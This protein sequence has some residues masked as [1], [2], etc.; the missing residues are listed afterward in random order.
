MAGSI[1]RS[2]AAPQDFTLALALADALPVLFF[3]ASMI[4]VARNV[5][6]VLFG[7]GAAVITLAGCGKVLWKI[8]LGVWKKNVVWLNRYFIPCQITGLLL[9]LAALAL[10]IPAM[11]GAQL[12]GQLLHF[13]SLLFFL[14]WLAG[15]AVMGWYRKNRFDNSL[16]AN[17]TAQLINTVTQGAL[18]LGIL[19]L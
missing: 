13:P 1:K 3:G 6:S 7:F 17:W 16:K 15:M 19:F 14:V 5:G 9:V 2:A 18:L 11:D 4:L 8:F 10:H 12:L